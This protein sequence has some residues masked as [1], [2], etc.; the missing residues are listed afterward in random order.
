MRAEKQVTRSTYRRPTASVVTDVLWILTGVLVV[1]LGFRFALKMFGANPEAGFVR[2]VYG[3]S[4]VFMAPFKAVFS[5]NQVS[6]N[7]FEWSTLLAIAVYALV[8]WGIVSLVD[9]VAR[10]TSVS[11]FEQTDAIEGSNPPPANPPPNPP[12]SSPPE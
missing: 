8:A 11:E 7:V 5:N 9:A 10:R 12:P 1:L 4:D 2:F 6:G 3:L